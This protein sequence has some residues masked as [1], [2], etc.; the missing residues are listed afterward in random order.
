MVFHSLKATAA[1]AHEDFGD[2]VHGRFPRRPPPAAAP[3]VA[4]AVPA[5]APAPVVEAKP[6]ELTEKL[7][8]LKMLFDNGLISQDEYNTKKLE[9][10][11][12]L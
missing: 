10:L 9:L 4:L 5:P 2:W 1:K 6:D 3:P 8:K 7:K 11:S 12:D